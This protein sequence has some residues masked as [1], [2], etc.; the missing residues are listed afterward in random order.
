MMEEAYS[1]TPAAASFCPHGYSEIQWAAV[2]ST[3]DIYTLELALG[4]ILAEP[5][6]ENFREF[7]RCLRFCKTLYFQNDRQEPGAYDAGAR[8]IVTLAKHVVAL[9]GA[10]PAVAKSNP[11][12]AEVRDGI[13]NLHI[14]KIE[15]RLATPLGER[16]NLDKAAFGSDWE[17]IRTV[18]WGALP[19]SSPT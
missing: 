19:A 7:C 15:E 1:E 5:G 16:P 10:G 12:L 2:R 11:E 14:R 8:H 17:P 18:D 3:L 13:D 9:I 6:P 4:R